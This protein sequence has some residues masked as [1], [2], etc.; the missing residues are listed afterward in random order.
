MTVKIPK[1][2]RA[3]GGKAVVLRRAWVTDAHRTAGPRVDLVG[4][5]VGWRIGSAPR[6]VHR[7]PPGKVTTPRASYSSPRAGG[8]W[9]TGFARPLLATANQP[10]RVWSRAFSAAVG[11]FHDRDQRPSTDRLAAMSSA[12]RDS[13]A[14][15]TEPAQRPSL[16]ETWPAIARLAFISVYCLTII[17]TGFGHWSLSTVRILNA[18]VA[19]LGLAPDHVDPAGTRRNGSTRVRPAPS[20][21]SDAAGRPL[22]LILFW[23]PIW[24]ILIVAAFILELRQLSAA[25]ASPS[26]S[27]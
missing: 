16:S 13:E 7:W 20:R 26:P 21:A 23:D 8:P 27:S 3:Q 12:E 11:N 4:E 19:V 9:R 25:T 5:A 1:R 15:D 24:F 10:G 18:I 14:A 22:F 2:G 17:T 6:R